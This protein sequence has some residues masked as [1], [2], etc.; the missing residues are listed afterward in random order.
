MMP[1]RAAARKAK[2]SRSRLAHGQ[3]HRP[4]C[5]RCGIAGAFAEG[6]SG[7][8]ATSAFGSRSEMQQAID[9]SQRGSPFLAI[10]R[11]AKEQRRSHQVE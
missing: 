9:D 6:L 10:A 7:A 8:C 1:N 5:R 4:A 11:I 2:H 3:T